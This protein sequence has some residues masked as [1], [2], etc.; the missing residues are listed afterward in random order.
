MEHTVHSNHHHTTH[1][2]GSMKPDCAA[3]SHMSARA[4][5]YFGDAPELGTVPLVK[6]PGQMYAGGP[7]VEPWYFSRASIL[8]ASGL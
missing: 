5:A 1:S 8:S 2:S 6:V 3:A 7:L 4:A